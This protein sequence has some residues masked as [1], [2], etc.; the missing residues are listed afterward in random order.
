MH[1]LYLAASIALV[2]A[3]A[4]P[5]A[6]DNNNNI[7]KR[8]VGPSSAEI[9]ACLNSALPSYSAVSYRY[10][11]LR[12]LWK[13]HWTNQTFTSSQEDQDAVRC[14]CYCGGYGC[15]NVPQS[16]VV[17]IKYRLNPKVPDAC[18]SKF[19]SADA[20][21]TPPTG[22]GPMY[23]GAHYDTENADSGEDDDEENT[24]YTPVRIAS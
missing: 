20:G 2:R 8:Y 23:Q 3:A 19:L 13:I 9:S 22:S 21:Q 18:Y 4:L 6:E 11:S 14:M 24:K 15:A 5:R 1:F 10:P 12:T 17:D 7:S 16:K